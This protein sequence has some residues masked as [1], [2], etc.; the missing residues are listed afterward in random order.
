VA[1]S[2]KTSVNFNPGNDMPQTVL[3]TIVDDAVQMQ[4]GFGAWAHMTARCSYNLY[5]KEVENLDINEQE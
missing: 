3:I 4:S 2:A 1:G 5:A